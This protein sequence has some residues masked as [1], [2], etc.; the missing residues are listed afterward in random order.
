M[1]SSQLALSPSVIPIVVIGWITACIVGNR[2]TVKALKPILDNSI[3]PVGLS[4]C[5]ITYI[6]RSIRKC[7]ITKNIS[8]IIIL[9]N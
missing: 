2:R 6:I 5:R 7:G 3:V 8:T 9:E 1:N 4:Y